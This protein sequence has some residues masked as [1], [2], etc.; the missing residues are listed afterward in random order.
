MSSHAADGS[1][2]S[3]DLR[4]DGQTRVE[5][6]NGAVNLEIDV[7]APLWAQYDRIEI[8]ANATTVPDGAYEYG[9]LPSIVLIRDVDFS[10]ETRSIDPSLPAAA[11]LETRG[12]VVPFTGLTEDTWF[13]VVVKGSDGVSTP[14]FPVFAASLDRGSNNSLDDLNDGN[15][16]EGGVMALGATNALYADVDGNPG[17]QLGL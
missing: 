1:G 14:M 3:A 5:T 7:Q 13:V 15:L 17:F 10:V 11:R 4:I 16:G 9:A 2:R 8:Y 12:L 6:S